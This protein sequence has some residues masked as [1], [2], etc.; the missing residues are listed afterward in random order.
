[1]AIAELPD[2]PEQRVVFHNIRWQGYETILEVLGDDRSAR[3][4]Y[5][6]GTLEITMPSEKHYAAT[7]MI[8]QF[9]RNLVFELGMKV[10]TMGSTKS[11]P[12][13]VGIAH[14]TVSYLSN[15][16]LRHRNRVYCLLDYQLLVTALLT[17]R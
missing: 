13:M 5:D 7:R 12:F 16:C 3:L 14:F 1:M 15:F 17:N 4:T 8:A 10:K 2:P 6:K 11:V 9:I